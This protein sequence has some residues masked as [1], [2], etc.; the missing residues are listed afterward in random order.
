MRASLHHQRIHALQLTGHKPSGMTLHRRARPVGQVGVGDRDGRLDGVDQRPQTGAEHDPGPGPGMNAGGGGRD[1]F[2]DLLTSDEIIHHHSCDSSLA[3]F[4]LNSASVI[5]PFLR[6]ASS[7]SI[8]FGT[9]RSV[10]SRIC[11]PYSPPSCAFA[12]SM[13]VLNVIGSRRRVSLLT[14]TSLPVTTSRSP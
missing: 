8:S 9:S 7:S 14:P 3:F 2:I 12:S 11:S 4:S 10:T 13:A 6:S 1:R 5:K